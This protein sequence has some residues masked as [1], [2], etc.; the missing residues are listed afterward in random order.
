MGDDETAPAITRCIISKLAT[1]CPRP[2][3]FSDPCRVPYR[4]GWCT[5]MGGRS[6]HAFLIRVRWPANSCSIFFL[7]N[8][9]AS[10]LS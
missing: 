10:P 5:R 2:M 7:G 4:L 9:K 3:V 1:C 6:A 8:T